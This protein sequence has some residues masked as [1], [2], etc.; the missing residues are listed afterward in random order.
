MTAWNCAQCPKHSRLGEGGCPAWWETV[1]T[2]VVDGSVNVWKECAWL[3]MPVYLIEV[4]KA[5]NRPAAAIE[6]T[7]NEIANGFGQLV[8]VLHSEAIR[9]LSR[10][11]DN[12]QLGEHPSAGV[13]GHCES[14]SANRGSE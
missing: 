14:A 11:N 13:S 7:R 4:I 3:Q 1:Q 9:K 10:P 5:S 2:N 12:R 6:S 8:E